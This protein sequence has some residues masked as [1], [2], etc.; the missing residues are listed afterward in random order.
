MGYEGFSG[1]ETILYHLHSP[2]RLDQRRRVPPDR[3][4]GVGPGHPRA[5]ARRHGPDRARRRSAE[6]APAADVQRRPR[7]LRLQAGRGAR[8]LLPQRRGRRGDLRA[9]RRRRAAH[10][11]RPGALPGEGLRRDPARDHAHLRA[12]GRRAGLALLPHPRRDRDAQPLPQPLRPA[13]RARAVLPARLPSARRDRDGRRERGVPGHRARARRPPG[14]PARPPPVRRGRLGRLRLA[15]HLQRRRLR[16][17]RRPLPPA[18]AGAPDL[19]GAELRDLHLRAADA[20]L[21]PRGRAAALPPLEHPVRGGHVLRGG[22]LRGAQGRRRRLHH[23]APV[24]PAARP[25]A[26]RRREGARVQAAPTSWP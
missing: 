16:A 4:R 2:C 6:R 13:A 15:V 10:R 9:P 21:G 8:R 1:N 7:G 17:A 19:P 12:G 3:A 22:R 20:R 5:P 11:L 18:A 25:A 26:R 24:R 14:L 23:P